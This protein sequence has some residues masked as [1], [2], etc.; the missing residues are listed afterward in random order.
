MAAPRR[1]SLEVIRWRGHQLHA[2]YDLDGYAFATTLWY[3][4]VDL[5][6]LER[7]IGDEAMHALAFHVAAFEINKLASLCPEEVSFGA[8]SRFVTPRFVDLW[9]TVLLKVWAQWRFEHD[10]P[11][12]KG[13][14]IVDRPAQAEAPP[15]VA[16]FLEPS[17]DVLLFFG[18]GKDSVVA[19]SLLDRASVSWSSHTYAHSVYGPPAPQLALVDGLLDV[20]S[21]RRR[22]RQWVADDAFAAPL[23]ELMPSGGSRSFLAAETP[24]SIF[25]ALPVVVAHGYAHMAL[26]HEHSANRGNLIWSSTGEDVNH[27]WGKSWHAERLLAAYVEE[28]LVP[29]FRWFSILQPLSDVVIFELLRGMADAVSLAHSCNVK[30]PWCL[31]CPKCAYV[32]LGYAAHLPDGLYEQVFSEDVLDLPENELSFRQMMGLGEHTPFECI[33]EIDEARLALALCAARG[34]RSRAVEIFRREGGPLDV[35]SVLARYAVLHD[36]QPHGIPTHLGA[37]VLPVMRDAAA[38]AQKRIRATLT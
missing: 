17:T 6:A 19:A 22:H 33:G 32:A 34:R 9:S 26:A 11:D 30:K 16:A 28:E 18:G 20:M 13:P 21:P 7:R 15:R 37:R 29:G 12:W 36:G 31:R 14:T 2:R 24:S 27:Q 35:E 25:G 1:L 23:N 5:E 4:D 8:W 38:A 3:G 10:R